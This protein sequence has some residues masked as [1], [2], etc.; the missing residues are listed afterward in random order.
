MI[1]MI[2]SL[3]FRSAGLIQLT[4]DHSF[5]HTSYLLPDKTEI[6]IPVCSAVSPS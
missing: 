2:L 1:Y 5:S 3:L 4:A 6:Y